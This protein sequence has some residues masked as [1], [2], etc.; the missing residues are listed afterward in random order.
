[1]TRVLHSLHGLAGQDLLNW[2][3]CLKRMIQDPNL[4]LWEKGFVIHALGDSYAHTFEVEGKPG[5]R[6]AYEYPV[7]HGRQGHEPDII[8]NDPGL[9]KQYVDDLGSA[10]KGMFSGKS[11]MNRIAGLNTLAKRL[12]QEKADKQ[13]PWL[14]QNDLF[15]VYSRRRGY[16]RKYT[17]D[18]THNLDLDMYKPSEARVKKLIERMKGCLKKD[19]CDTTPGKTF[20]ST[21]SG[22]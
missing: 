4:L 2:R 10:F 13:E 5:V 7:G 12:A 14:G 18:D 17:P 15:E 11:D 3:N 8:A 9:Y 20:E 1:M 21:P 22:K 16:K 19:P 6:K